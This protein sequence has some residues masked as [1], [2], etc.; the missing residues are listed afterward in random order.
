MKVIKT[1]LNGDVYSCI[2]L[3]TN[4]FFYF[5]KNGLLHNEIGPAFFYFIKNIK[6]GY[7]FLNGQNYA[8]VSSNKQWKKFVKSEK[9][10]IF[11]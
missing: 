1:S 3:K 2:L 8:L 11:I 4:N 6:I 9:F 5:Y 10:K 7:Y